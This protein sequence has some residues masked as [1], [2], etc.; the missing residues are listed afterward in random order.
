MKSATQEGIFGGNIFG[1]FDFVS[2]QSLLQK[3]IFCIIIGPI[4]PDKAFNHKNK[5]NISPDCY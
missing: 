4:S 1:V 5:K 2:M 3:R